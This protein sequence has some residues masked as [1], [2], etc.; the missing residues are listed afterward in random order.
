MRTVL[1]TGG[2]GAIGAAICE[3]LAKDSD[4]IFTYNTS[5]DK[6]AELE[7]KLHCTA[8]K[9]DVSDP[10]D[11]KNLRDTVYKS[12]PKIDVLVN[13][14]GISQIKLFTDITDYEWQNMININL[15]S[16]F[17]VTKAF[18]PKMISAK[19]GSIINISSVWGVHGASCEVHY[20][21]AK[22]GLIGLT[23][24][25]SKE[26][27]PSGI[28]VNCIAPGVIDTPMNAHLGE[29]DMKEL[30]E[31]T[32]LSKIGKPSDIAKLVR[33]LAESEFVTGQTIGID[34]GF[35]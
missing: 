34:G 10:E 15:N 17:Y 1:V 19:S 16:A 21:A 28:S 31:A 27:G 2:S 33:Y 14:A 29:D 5:A 26:V 24:A 11:V 6:A 4:I 18:L 9:C 20:S 8:V 13:N 25:L 30:I 35:Y 3:E 23:K 32:P 12:Y 22:A 7:A